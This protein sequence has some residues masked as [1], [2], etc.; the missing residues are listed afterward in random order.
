MPSEKNKQTWVSEQKEIP[1]GWR[2]PPDIS[3]ESSPVGCFSF[4]EIYWVFSRNSRVFVSSWNGSMAYMPLIRRWSQWKRQE[5]LQL[6]RMRAGPSAC[7][8]GWVC[9]LSLF[10]VTAASMLPVMH[11]TVT[12]THQELRHPVW[13]SRGLV[14]FIHLLD[15]YSWLP[16]DLPILYN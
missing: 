9:I 11:C 4:L 14:L 6:D 7:L 13:H 8:Q 3:G 1:E 5:I 15:A 12:L 2:Y 16:I 10:P